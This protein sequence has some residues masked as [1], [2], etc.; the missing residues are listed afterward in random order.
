MPHHSTRRLLGFGFGFSLG[1]CHVFVAN[2]DGLSQGRII[3]HKL[4]P[5][6]Q[7]AYRLL[8]DSNNLKSNRQNSVVVLAELK[9]VDSWCSV[10]APVVITT[11][12]NKLASGLVGSLSND[13][14]E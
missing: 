1:F 2:P 9:R 4:N 13:L 12:P 5:P 10:A 3:L 14:L 6:I 11:D 8:T 7:I